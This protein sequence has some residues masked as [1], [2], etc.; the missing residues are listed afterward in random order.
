MRRLLVWVF[1]LALAAVA[2]PPLYFHFAP[3][4]APRLPPIGLRIAVG[5]DRAVNA[6]VKGE[7]PTLVLVHGLPGCSYDWSPLAESLAARGFRTLAYDRIGYGYSDGRSDDDFTIAANAR[8]L[9]ALLASQG[10]RDVTLI[11]WSY[12]APVAIEAAGR[13]GS[14]IARLVLVGGAGPLESMGERPPA[15]LSKLMFSGPVLAWLH[16]VPP[17]GRAVQEAM[18]REA[19]SGEP[20]AWWLPQLAANLGAPHSLESFAGEN[21]RFEDGDAAIDPVALAQPI[22]LIHGD[23]DHLVPLSAARWIESHARHAELVVVKGGS[24]MLPITHA[25]LLADR[26]ASFARGDASARD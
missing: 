5:S 25:E 16:A 4:E 17:V 20:P 24:H 2:L 15:A 26:I 21:A 10:L 13:D 11:G 6:V 22:L 9:V 12:G 14:R 1:V 3:V 8:E 19:F 23:D 7:G 18:S